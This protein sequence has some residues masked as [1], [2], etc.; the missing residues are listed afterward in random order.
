MKKLIAA[1]VL[2]AA[3]MLVIAAGFAME[4]RS[5]VQPIT[6]ESPCPA[7]GCANGACHGFGAV[8]EPD[9]VHEMTCPEA[10]CSATECHAWDSLTSRYHQA[11][12]MSLNVW[13]LVP[14]V[15]VLAL[16]LMA[17]RMGRD[18]RGRVEIEAAD[19]KGV[20]HEA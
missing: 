18:G 11:S 13:I 3:A 2:A 20:C 19:E 10:G 14:T 15:L 17:R 16:W 4:P 7:V 8:P 12:D 6:V 5:A 1:G 9:G